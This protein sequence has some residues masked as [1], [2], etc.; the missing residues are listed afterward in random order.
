MVPPGVLLPNRAE[1]GPFKHFDV[2]DAVHRMRKTVE[3]VAVGELV[4]VDARVHATDGEA[5][6]KA[7]A[8][9]TT[10]VDAADIVDGVIQIGAALFGDHGARHDHHALRQVS[11]LGPG[12]IRRRSLFERC[13]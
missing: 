11:E 3:L 7:V 13:R 6:E 2:L 10:K 4:A 1:P 5:I 12:L 8:R 9:R